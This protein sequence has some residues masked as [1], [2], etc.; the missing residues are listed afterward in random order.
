MTATMSANTVHT[1]DGV[2]LHVSCWGDG[3]PVLLVHAWALSGRMWDYQIPAIVGAGRSCVVVDRRGHGRSG[4]TNSGY[5]LDTLADDLAV[6]IEQLDLRD[7]TLV[8]HS[9]GAQEI[10]R[11]LTR[12][13]SGRVASVVL[14]APMTPCV[15]QRD[16][17][18]MGVPEAD[19]EATRMTWLTDFG[20]WVTDNTDGYFGQGSVS[21]PLADMSVR[22][23]MDT[24]LPVIVETH[25]TLT[26][27]D[28]RP[29][30]ER[31][32]VPTTI[33]QGSCDM[34]APID[35]TGRLTATLVDGAHLSVIEGGG[36]GMYHGH[37]DEYNEALV[38]AIR[39]S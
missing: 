24:P 25:R 21:E 29:D 22:M 37:C 6:V 9:M 36:H 14:S 38:E 18:P 34:S 30:L 16:D 3:P 28:L 19:F 27:A 1:G 31:L 13:G 10:L 7:L 15:L 2:D 4:R 17:Y 39:R 33:I 12:H 20:T 32:D 23:M 8:G 26:R 5:D 11:Y 35:A